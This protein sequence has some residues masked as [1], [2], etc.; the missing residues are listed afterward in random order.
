M[1]RQFKW[2]TAKI[3]HN[4]LLIMGV[5]ATPI[6]LSMMWGC[7]DRLKLDDD[8][9]SHNQE[10]TPQRGDSSISDLGIIAMGAIGLFIL[11]NLRFT[12]KVTKK[13]NLNYADLKDHNLSKADL[14]GADLNYANLSGA[15]LTS[16]NLRYANLRGADLS[17]ADLSE[18]NFT[19]ANLSGASLRYAN[20]SRANLTS[21]NL[22]GADLN[23][24]LLRGANFSDANLSGAL[25]F[26]LNSR[27][28]HNLE[29]LQLLAKP[30][31]FLCHVALP[32]YSQPLDLNPNRDC[33]LIPQLLSDRYHI[34]LT[35]AQYILNE[36]RRHQWH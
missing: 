24:A 6:L 34:S 21:A 32:P 31:P 25:L 27:D 29:P 20:L 3:K 2:W 9:L 30:S 19:Y 5:I 10:P 28:V 11:L 15:N 23:C 7:N 16:A 13:A 33:H 17:G 12:S 4:K 8:H 22:S 1:S 36:A 35:E 18:T 26:F 14:S